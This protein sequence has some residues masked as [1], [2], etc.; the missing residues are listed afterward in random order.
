MDFRQESLHPLDTSVLVCGWQ[1][2]KIKISTLL[3][4]HL[5]VL[6][7]GKYRPSKCFKHHKHLSWCKFLA[8]NIRCFVVNYLFCRIFAFFFCKFQKIKGKSYL[9][10][11]IS[12]SFFLQTNLWNP[13]IL[14][15]IYKDH[16]Q[17]ILFLE[18]F[19]YY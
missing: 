17:N 13:N 11:F 18:T 9:Y 5:M 2:H 10:T 6:C 15:F 12:L 19:L 1:L 4:V 7:K 16:W 14:S 3:A 8:L